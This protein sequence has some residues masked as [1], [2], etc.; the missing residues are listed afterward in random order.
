VINFEITKEF[1]E[2]LGMFAADGCMQDNYICM[3]GNINEDKEYYDK[4]V[5]SLFSKVSGKQIIAHEKKSNSVYGFYLCDRKLIELLKGIGFRNNK[6]Y[7]VAVPLII[8]ENSDLEIISAFIR[9]Y[10]DCDGCIY[11]QKRKGNYSLFN[12]SFNTYPKVEID[13]VSKKVIE[14]ISFM[15]NLFNIN[16][17]INI[18]LNKKI[19]EATK[20]RIMIRGSERV[21]LFMEKIG[22]N[23]ISKKL[24][25]DIWKKFGF[26]PIKTT[27]KERKLILEDKL[28][29]KSF[30]RFG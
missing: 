28:D 27:I 1:S 17:K 24:K 5:C 21:N 22:F 9:G 6:T 16:H 26:C 13:S 12:R 29:P 23:N 19:N 14:D 18:T 25:Y 11:F 15:L 4:I 30:Y 20:Y 7:N 8:K 2:V 10:A 3:W